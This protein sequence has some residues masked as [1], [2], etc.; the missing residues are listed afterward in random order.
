VSSLNE[1][2]YHVFSTLV[3]HYPVFDWDIHDATW[4]QFKKLDALLKAHDEKAIEALCSEF[5]V[6]AKKY[7]DNLL[8]EID[9]AYSPKETGHTCVTTA[10]M[11]HEPQ[12]S[13]VWVGGPVVMITRGMWAKLR[14]TTRRGGS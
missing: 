10:T 9:R 6:S 5:G 12:G 11:S 3:R 8:G 2:W 7:I 13:E 1:D 4:D 14:D